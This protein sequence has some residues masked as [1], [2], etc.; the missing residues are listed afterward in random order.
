M[1]RTAQKGHHW[2]WTDLTESLRGIKY[3]ETDI[4]LSGQPVHEHYLTTCP[5]SWVEKGYVREA[6]ID[7][8]L[9]LF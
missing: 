9:E 8:Q 3:P 4:R 2:V 7:G 6:Q 1:N 5:L